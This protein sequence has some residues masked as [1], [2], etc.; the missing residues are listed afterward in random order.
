MAA[1]YKPNAKKP[2][3]RQPVEHKNGELRKRPQAHSRTY[4]LPE[5]PGRQRLVDLH[6]IGLPRAVRGGIFCGGQCE[7]EQGQP[8]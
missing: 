4:G 3:H 2:Q 7:R 1:G 8:P 6:H 5:R